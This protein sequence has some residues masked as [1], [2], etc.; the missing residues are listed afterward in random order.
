MNS[1][2][3]LP[4]NALRVFEAVARH[5]SMTKAAQALNVQ[6]S[7]VSMQMKNL[8]EHIG[9]P[10]VMKVG[11]RLELSAAGTTLL[12]AVVAGLGQ[13]EDTVTTL[14]KAAE[15]APFTLSVL[16]SYLHTWLMPRLP[17]FEAANPSCRVQLLVSRELADL[18]QGQVHAAVRLGAGHW[19]GLH[20]EHL[21]DEWLLPVCAPKLSKRVGVVALGHCPAGVNLLHGSV[22]PWSLWA[23]KTAPAR[24]P[25][26]TIDDAFAL[27]TAAEAER[28]VALARWSVAQPALAAGRL[29]A[30]GKRIRYRYAYYWVVR[31]TRLADESAAA[32]TGAALLAWLRVQSASV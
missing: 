20:A 13:I 8:T 24:A 22:D 9:T 1:F 12:G 21:M 25:T 6:P 29:V 5:G 10:L 7:A 26:L 30:V 4:L 17:A 23:G 28:G 32:S 3:R 19:P 11:K 27:V 31:D 2:P 16:P 15:N 18:N 14:R